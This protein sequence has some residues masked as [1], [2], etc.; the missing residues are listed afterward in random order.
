[1]GDGVCVAFAGAGEAGVGGAERG[2]GFVH[3]PG[4]AGSA[5]GGGGGAFYLGGGHDGYPLVGS[6]FG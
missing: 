1:V 2:I 4:C 6:S 3:G 5:V